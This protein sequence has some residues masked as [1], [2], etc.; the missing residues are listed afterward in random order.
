LVKICENLCEIPEN[1]DK[2]HENLSKNGAQRVFEN[3]AKITQ[4][5]VFLEV[6]PKTV[7]MRKY[8]TRSGPKFFRAEI[9]HTPKNYLL[10]QPMEWS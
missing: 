9:L 5:P 1:L 4:K 3:G 6:I 2:L 7:V 8:R 10:L